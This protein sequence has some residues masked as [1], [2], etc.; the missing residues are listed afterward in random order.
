MKARVIE[1]E[2]TIDKIKEVKER[3]GKELEEW[4]RE[5][6]LIKARLDSI[7]SNLFDNVL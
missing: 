6:Q 7:D 5:I 3:E 1:F 4:E 2:R